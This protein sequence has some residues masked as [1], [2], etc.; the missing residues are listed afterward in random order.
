VECYPDF[1][2]SMNLDIYYSIED[3]D[4]FG[5]EVKSWS[6]DQ[7]LV[8]YAEILGSVDRDAIKNNMLFEYEGKLIG[9]SRVDP[10]TSMSGITY[11]I[12]SIII[13]NIRD[14]NTGQEFYTES[15][16][17]RAGMST[18]FEIL[19]V[20]PYVNPWNEIEYYKI[21]FNRSDF[22]GLIEND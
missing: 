4:K 14:I 11:P 16:G 7:T 8:G 13:T 12:S 15:F 20:E 6:F 17:D 19:S 3:Q 2:F 10:R 18:I 21:L 1:L 9:R 5:T 22:Q